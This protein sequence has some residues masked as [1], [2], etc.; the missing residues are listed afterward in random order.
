MGLK[1]AGVFAA[2]SGLGVVYFALGIGTESPKKEASARVNP[3]SVGR[4][5]KPVNAMN[6]A[7]GD[8]VFLAQDLGFGV[9]NAKGAALE[10]NKI[11]ARV[12]SQLQGIREIYRQ[13]VAKNP[14][15]VGAMILQLTVSSAGEVTD[16][17]EVSS[18]LGDT[19]FRKAVLAAA[20]KWSFSEIAGESLTVTCPLLFVH[21]G[22]DL[23]TLVRWEKSLGDL[24]GVTGALRLAA[25][26]PAAPLKSTEAN[27]RAAKGASGGN[28]DKA[29]PAAPKPE[30]KEFQVKYAT[31]LRK[32]PNFSAPSLT[33]FTIGTR[34]TVL[35]KQGDWLEV[36]AAH[37]GPSGFI[38]KEFV[39]PAEVARR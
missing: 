33:T 2:A 18:R 36:R 1:A 37:D 34:V 12:E 10:S 20:A 13:E 39:T 24:P 25:A 4:Q 26:G 29:M 22:M 16:V 11:A 21:E 31:K 5:N 19:D 23:T 30:S 14:S 32:E 9:A 17:K 7:L 28:G 6:V 8:M 3:A 27:T 35:R 15:L 38:R